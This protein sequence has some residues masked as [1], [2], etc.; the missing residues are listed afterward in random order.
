MIRHPLEP[1]E[2]GYH[3]VFRAT[4]VRVSPGLFNAEL[5]VT[6]AEKGGWIHWIGQPV[7]LASHDIHAYRQA[8]DVCK[9]SKKGHGQKNKVST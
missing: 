4:K 9:K 7:R 3:L 8:V 1:L 2:R 6:L 5:G